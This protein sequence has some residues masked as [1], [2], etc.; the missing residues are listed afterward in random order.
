[1]NMDYKLFQNKQYFVTAIGTDIGKTYFTLKLH[2]ILS[3]SGQKSNIIKPLIS[4]FDLDNNNDTIQILEALN[5]ERNT[6]NLDKISPFRL[7]FPLSPDISAKREGIKLDFNKISDF[8]QKNI[9]KSKKN[10][11]FL[12]IEGAGGV[13]SPLT[14]NKTFLD[15]MKEL[16]IPVILI[17]SNYLGS[18]S[19]TLTAIKIL[20]E[21]KIDIEYI[22]FNF[23]SEKQA[24]E[25]EEMLES[26]TKF[27]DHK[28][29]TI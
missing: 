13:M 5:L 17:T 7:K 12:L 21:Y 10:N 9:E 22:I 2:N 16:Q 4:G 20:E 1:M 26:L 14:S 15:L 29:I 25:S 27:T 18:I 11:E 8:C 24:G 28:I 3:Q 23:R 6:Q 19:H